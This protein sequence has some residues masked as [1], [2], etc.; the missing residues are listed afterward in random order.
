MS[1]MNFKRF[2]FILSTAAITSAIGGCAAD[3]TDESSQ[4][5]QATSDELNAQQIFCAI[6]DCHQEWQKLGETSVDGWA[7]DHDTIR[8]DK[9]EGRFSRIQLRLRG[10]GPVSVHDIVV[11]FRNGERFHV[12]DKIEFDEDGE[13]S[14]VIDL[15]GDRRAIKRIDLT[16]DRFPFF[17]GFGDQNQ[18]PPILF[19][20]PFPNNEKVNV[21]VW[22]KR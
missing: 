4:P 20:F 12:Q 3:D 13:R 5:T 19:A 8:V 16:S 17:A 6:W 7:D 1:V 18:P 11:T 9:E 2:F 22:A 21:E 14:H 15:P 10:E